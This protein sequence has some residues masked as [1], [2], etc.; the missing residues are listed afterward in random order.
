[1]TDPIEEAKRDVEAAAA[2]DRFSKLVESLGGTASASAVFG[3][4]VEKDGVTIVPVARVRYGV[5]GGGGR[6]AGRKKKRDGA[7]AEQEVGYGHGGGVQAAP[8][9]YIELRD[10]QTRYKRIADPVRPMAMLLLF[11]LVGV[12]SFAAMAAISLQ[13]AKSMRG[14]L[15]TLPHL[16]LPSLHWRP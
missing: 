1:M 15:P 5:G 12:I 3:A 2:G 10:G 11:P 16:Q 9:G 7:D 6:G 14:M 13:V 8:V 4:A